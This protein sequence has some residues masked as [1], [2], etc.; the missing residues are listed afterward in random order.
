[1]KYDVLNTKGSGV[2]SVTKHGV[3]AGRFTQ[4]NPTSEDFKAI[5]GSLNMTH[6]SAKTLDELN[7][8]VA[9]QTPPNGI[10]TKLEEA[11]KANRPLVVKLGFDPTAPDLHLG[12]AVVLRKMR[13]FQNAGHKL[14]VIIGDFTAR[15]GD[16]T[17]RNKARPPLSEEAVQENAKTY[18]DQLS[19]VL[20][21]DTS[22]L[23]VRFNAEWLGKMNFT[24]VVKLLSKATVAQLL[25]REDFNKRYANN[26]PIG[27]HEMLYPLMQGYDSIAIN[28]DIEMGGTD[29]LFN[30]LVGRAL[31]EGDG[32]PGQ[33]VVSMPL[34]VGLDGKEK[35]SKSHNNYIGLTEEP[36][37]M[38][39]KAMSIPDHLLPNYLDLATD[40]SHDTIVDLKEQL[41]A[42]TANPMEVK[43]LIAE[44]IVKQ[45]HDEESAKAAAAFFYNQFQNKAADEKNY[46]SIDASTVFEG[47]T[48]INLID[49]CAKLQPD[50]SRTQMRRLISSSAVSLNGEKLSDPLQKVECPK[51]VE[52]KLRIGKRGFFALTTNAK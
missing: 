24:D 44:N 40:F 7:R 31:Q 22:R 16:P 32:K 6:P 9:I 27:M 10:R 15:I 52:L 25:Q 11:K 50:V 1:M 47:E 2:Q 4:S 33:I 8:G 29:Q 36:N 42:G 19:K 3:A 46:E 37:Q 43:K 39:G 34:L 45:Y 12:H 30:C 13:Q 21:T 20:D 28:A 18:L 41:G 14:V 17:G 5:A 35:M 26:I 51:E 49:L 48:S 23:E 38:Y